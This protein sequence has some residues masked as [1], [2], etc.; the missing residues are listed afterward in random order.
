MF[1]NSGSHT[2]HK[3]AKENPKFRYHIVKNI[4]DYII[5]SWVGRG[6]R[7]RGGKSPPSPWQDVKKDDV[8][9]DGMPHSNEHM[10][11][12]AIFF[13]DVGYPPCICFLN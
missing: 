13:L 3:M 6:G 2:K 7:G 11:H 9:Q 5:L 1:F 4:Y 8:E 10:D 12:G